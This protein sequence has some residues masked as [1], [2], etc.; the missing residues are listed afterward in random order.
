[1]EYLIVKTPY[2]E[3]WEREILSSQPAQGHDNPIVN[4]YIDCN[5]TQDSASAE[6]LN[7]EP[8]SERSKEETPHASSP[9]TQSDPPAAESKKRKAQVNC[10]SIPSIFNWYLL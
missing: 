10:L 5:K 9:S 4:Q 7:S 8:D 2:I 1:M 3:K 6:R